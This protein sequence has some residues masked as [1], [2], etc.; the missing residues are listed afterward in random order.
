VALPEQDRQEEFDGVES[1][2]HAALERAS[3]GEE[4]E[5]DQALTQGEEQW[6][7]QDE[8]EELDQGSL[9]RVGD[10]GLEEVEGDD[11]EGEEDEVEEEGDEEEEEEEGEAVTTGATSSSY[12]QSFW[13]R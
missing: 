2:H 10:E 12:L 1:D 3:A 11:A 7:E 4:D 13:G 5:A 6:A 9:D 8:G